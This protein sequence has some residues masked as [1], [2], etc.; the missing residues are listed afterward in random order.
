LRAV[1]E[2]EA[3][4]G[5][6][7][8]IRGGASMPPI[9]PPSP[10]ARSG[11]MALAE[12]GHGRTGKVGHRAPGL[13]CAR[14]HAVPPRHSPARKPNP[15]SRAHKP[16]TA[17]HAHLFLALLRR[18]GVVRVVHLRYAGRRRGECLA[19]VCGRRE[20]RANWLFEEQ[21][22]VGRP[23]L[24]FDLS[25]SLLPSTLLVPP[26]PLTAHTETNADHLPREHKTHNA[27]ARPHHRPRRRPAQAQG[28][29]GGRP[30][31]GGGAAGPGVG[32]ALG[33]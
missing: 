5:A 3:G 15:R 7:C 33:A 28:R 13:F 19:G 4:A 16:L 26:P 27:A 11:R 12:S 32:G 23:T 21:A 20:T 1:A 2:R 29:P 18:H 14:R 9:A 30:G 22:R 24:L 31:G 10:L 17:H 25:P 6:A 8:V